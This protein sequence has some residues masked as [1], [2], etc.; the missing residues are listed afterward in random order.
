MMDPVFSKLAPWAE[1]PALA[2]IPQGEPLT[3][4]VINNM[5][6]AALHATELQF[7]RLLGAASQGMTITLKFYSPPQIARSAAAR[8][9]IE[10]YY[11][12][13]ATLEDD[14]PQ[15]IIV[16]GA[17]PTADRLQNDRCWEPI[18]KLVDWAIDRS[19]PGIWSCLASHVAVLHLDGISRQP[20][21]EKVSGVYP[22]R[23]NRNAYQIVHGMPSSWRVPH[24]RLNGLPERQL[25]SHGY[26]VL[27]KSPEVGVDIFSR[28]QGAL[29]LFFQGHPEYDANSLVAEFRRDIRRYLGG[30]A[31]RFPN[32]PENCFR[33]SVEAQILHLANAARHRRAPELLAGFDFIL[34][35]QAPEN[36]WFPDARRIYMNW[37]SYVANRRA[38]PARPRSA[39]ASAAYAHVA[40]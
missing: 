26:A 22:C 17:E 38:A 6:D 40:A 27:S 3:V 15:A 37:L 33:P 18:A 1:L 31:D 8:A 9:H 21:Q 29:Q 20:L 13:F 23:I 7:C 30:A 12:D 34:K 36:L 28:K 4:A 2:T 16:T 11:E 35:D 14:P 25:I 5:S 32:I 10:Q 24:S 19:I 39:A